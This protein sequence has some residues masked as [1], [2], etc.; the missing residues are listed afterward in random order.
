MS[1]GFSRMGFQQRVALASITLQSSGIT[2]TI[3]FSK[4]VVCFGKAVL[5]DQ[6]VS[7]SASVIPGSYRR[8][9]A[10][11]R[12]TPFDL[13]K[14]RRADRFFYLFPLVFEQLRFDFKIAIVNSD[15][16]FRE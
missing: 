14:K 9:I 13:K 3:Q 15:R 8:P 4:R 1:M 11:E 2:A 5:K 6:P 16:R 7:H 10:N 12:N